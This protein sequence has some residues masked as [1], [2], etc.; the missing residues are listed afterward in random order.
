MGIII[1]ASSEKVSSGHP[2]DADLKLIKI[3][4]SVPLKHEEINTSQ[5]FMRDHIIMTRVRAGLI[6]PGRVLGRGKGP[7]GVPV[8]EATW[9]L[10]AF[11]IYEIIRPLYALNMKK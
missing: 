1:V 8:G 9:T 7:I 2:L 6:A 10:K 11:D 4:A 3:A 5:M